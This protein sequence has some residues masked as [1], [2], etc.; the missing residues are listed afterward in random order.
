MIFYYIIIYADGQDIDDRFF[1]I[2]RYQQNSRAAVG[3]AVIG[4]M[5]FSA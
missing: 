4:N 3:S 1:I 2:F 5:L